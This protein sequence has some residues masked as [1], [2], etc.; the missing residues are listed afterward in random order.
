MIDSI[1]LQ[2]QSTR[3]Y[4]SDLKIHLQRS[5]DYYHTEKRLSKTNLRNMYMFLG[6]KNAEY[7]TTNDSTVL[8]NIIIE[9]LKLK[10]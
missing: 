10:K 8:T 7:F 5:S 4:L 3:K 6:S 2:I 1:E 9:K